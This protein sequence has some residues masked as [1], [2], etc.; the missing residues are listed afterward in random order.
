M[1]A[2]VTRRETRGTPNH[3]M[4]RTMKLF[5]LSGTILV[6]AALAVPPAAARQDVALRT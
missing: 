4:L 3:T 1:M 2:P 6:A 5:M